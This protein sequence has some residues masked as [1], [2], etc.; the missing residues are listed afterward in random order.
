MKLEIITP[1]Q[2]YFSGEVTSVTLPGTSGL[3]TVWENHAPL[4]SSLMKGKISY[5]AG[6]KETVLNIESG[7]A[8]VS[9]NIVTVCLELI[10]P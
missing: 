10:N 2:I 8:E 4:I 5:L 1:E 7:F 9:K 3:F 6:N